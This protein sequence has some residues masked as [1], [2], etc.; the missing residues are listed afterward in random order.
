MSKKATIEILL[1]FPDPALFPNR[2]NG[3]HWATRQPAK[4]LAKVTAFEKCERLSVVGT[5][6]DHAMTITVAPPD[7]RRRDVDGILSA[8]KPSIDGIAQALKIDDTHFNP[9]EIERVKPIEGG[10]VLITIER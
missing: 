9:I 8:L 3:K 2:S 4:E 10:R 7:R 1:P 6:I 5:Q